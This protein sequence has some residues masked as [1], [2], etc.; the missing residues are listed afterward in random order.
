MQARRVCG[1]NAS[2]NAEVIFRVKASPKKKTMSCVPF[3]AM[4]QVLQ[5]F[6]L[7]VD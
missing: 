4:Q 7:G 3:H 1:G 5:T 2:N 6:S